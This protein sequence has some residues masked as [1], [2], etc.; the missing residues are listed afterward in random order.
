LHPVSPGPAAIVQR[1]FQLLQSGRPGQAERC[2]RDALNLDPGHLPALNLLAIALH[3]QERNGEA[4]TLLQQLTRCEPASRAHWMNLG[5]VLRALER[6]V[7]ALAA[8]GRAAAL[9]ES[10][11][12]LLYNVGLL[13]IDLAEYDAAR[14]ALAEAHALSP[15]DAE[16]SYQY[17]SACCETLH[18]REGLAAL[19]S[20]PQARGL[21]TELV[22][23][24][25]TV[26]LR[27]G[28]PS[29]ADQ[30]LAVALSDPAP[31]APALLQLVHAFER[32]NRLE[33]ARVLLD[34]LQVHPARASLGSD[35]AAAEATLAQREARHD[36]AVRLYSQLAGGCDD[37]ERKHFYLFPLA[38]SLDALG[39]YDE[40]FVTLCEAH[41]SQAQLIERTLPDVVARKTD[42]MRV[43]RFG[44]DPHDAAE[45]SHDGAPPATASPIFIVAF[46]R[47]GTTLL[48]QTLDAHP[49][50]QSMDEQPFLQNAIE[51]IAGPGVH[52]PERM[53]ALTSA[54]LHDAREY[55][56]SL[57]RERI[58]LAPAQQLIDKNPLNVLRLPVIARLFPHARIVL[59]IRHPC[60]V[61]LSCFMQHFRPEFAWHCRDLRTLALAYRRTFEFWY[62]Q[63][64]LLRPA[65]REVRYEMLVSKF[66]D[67]VRELASFLEL[68]WTDAML[69]PGEHA[70]TR[71]LISAPS[72]SQVVQPVHARSVDRWRAYER[73]LRPVVPELLP[74]LQRWGYGA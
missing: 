9:G 11:A 68:P 54:Q 65:V 72:Y 21:T 41:A 50:L 16:I 45:W 5:T 12:T 38:S 39:R 19:Q 53:A 4:V 58:D 23:K 22:A 17:A 48:E 28:D 7:E 69:A 66:D 63:S 29:G 26:L 74:C 46:P 30:A 44:C 43:T 52:Y 67:E 25:G 35:L 37:A 57:V 6:H 14:Q 3:A 24:I 73:H 59:A 34:R 56:W 55:Y 8:Y 61:L 60:D 31:D 49:R 70:R 1:G 27:L 15:D 32:L 40:A 47:S 42:T 13:H 36:D 33:Q 10:S 71:G 2:G 62:Q 20:W 64:A 51:R 18:T